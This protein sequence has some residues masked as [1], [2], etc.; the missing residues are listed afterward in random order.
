MGLNTN[1]LLGKAIL[2][3]KIENGGIYKYKED[4]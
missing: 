2:M 3:Y 4:K 1:T